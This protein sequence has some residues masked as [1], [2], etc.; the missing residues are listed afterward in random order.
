LAHTF[1]LLVDLVWLWR[2]TDHAKDI[3]ILLLGVFA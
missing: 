3:E 1:A 2:H